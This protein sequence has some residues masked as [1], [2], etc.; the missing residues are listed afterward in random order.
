MILECFRLNALADWYALTDN[1]ISFKMSLVNMFLRI[2]LNDFPKKSP[3]H[4]FV[5]MVGIDAVGVVGL[6]F[7]MF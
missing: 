5:T 6:L 3:N 7:D 4:R 2:Q 1:P